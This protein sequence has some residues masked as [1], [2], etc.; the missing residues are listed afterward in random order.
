MINLKK[1]LYTVLS[2]IAL[3]FESI[4]G[5]I[6]T[7]YQ[8][9]WCSIQEIISIG[10]PIDFHRKVAQR[11]AATKAFSG[12]KDQNNIA[13]IAISIQGGS[14]ESRK[15]VFSEIEYLI[16]SALNVSIEQPLKEPSGKPIIAIP[17][18]F[19]GNRLHPDSMYRQNLVKQFL[20]FLISEEYTKNWGL[21]NELQVTRRILNSDS[22]ELKPKILIENSAKIGFDHSPSLAKVLHCEQTMIFKML[23]DKEIL[24]QLV[25]KLI[26]KMQTESIEAFLENN[27]QITLDIVTYNDMCPKCFATCFNMRQ[28]LQSYINSLLIEKL[29]KLNFLSKQ[30]RFPV[31]V[32]ILISSFRPFKVNETEFSRSIYK[33]DPTT[34]LHFIPN[35]NLQFLYINALIYPYPINIFYSTYSTNI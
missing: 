29:D 26:C 9:S 23:T 21:F 24:S 34:Y 13:T 28:R 35:T 11:I 32:T 25:D 10:L 8:T 31:P 19:V 18:I 20:T 1:F 4:S 6:P 15:S 7:P 27:P 3:F 22:H 33:K 14:S 2:I 12:L 16:S 17:D 5:E 30:M